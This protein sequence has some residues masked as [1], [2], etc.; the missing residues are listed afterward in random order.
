MNHKKLLC[1]ILAA[2]LAL[3]WGVSALAKMPSPTKEF[4]YYDEAKVLSEATRGEIFFSNEL[5]HDACGAQIV[6]AAVRTTGSDSIGDYTQ[7]LFA[8]WGIG[9]AETENGFLLVMAID[10]D[11]YYATC[12]D[13]LQPKLTSGT[14]NQYFDDYLE[15]DFAAKNYDAGARKFFE[16]I[17]ARVA[18][19][20][21]ADVT[22]EQGIAKYEAWKAEGGSGAW[23]AMPGG[24]RG[25]NYDDEEGLSPMSMITLIILLMI[26]L[27]VLR[28]MMRRRRMNFPLPP[29]PTVGRGG[30]RGVNYR[31]PQ[32]RSSRGFDDNDW[33]IFGILNGI[34]RGL[35]GGSGSSHGRSRSSGSSWSSGS[36]S[37]SSGS[38]RS[39]GSAS[40]GGGHSSGG[41]AGRGRH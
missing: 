1:A 2:L 17:F 24:A 11:T 23:S 16:A 20:Y 12:G 40:G 39:F 27:S 5:L 36:S 32:R 33:L 4:Y 38:S 25:A 7:D 19:T 3:A 18:D 41:G 15:A 37:R 6:V 28:R 34:S 31:G 8:A 21:N 30:Y 22:V 14:L 26:V 29:P 9:D 10:D 13:N 35:G